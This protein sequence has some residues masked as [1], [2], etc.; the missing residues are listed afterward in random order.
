MKKWLALFLAVVMCCSLLAACGGSD[1]Q[2]TTDPQ[3]SESQ[4]VENPTPDPT[5]SVS[6]EPEP[7]PEPEPEVA[8]DLADYLW[9]IPEDA[10]VE[11]QIKLELRNASLINA[12][13]LIFEPESYS[14][15]SKA[16]TSLRSKKNEERLAKVL[17]AKAGLVQE[18]SVADGIFF[19]WND[20]ESMPIVDGESYTEEQL[21]AASLLGYGYSTVLVK[22]LI[23]DPTQAKGNIVVVSGGAMKGRA[24]GSEGYP[25]VEVFNA[26]GYNC[27]LLQRRLEPYS[28]MDI[29]MDFQR[30]VRTVRYYAEQEG[31]G[32]Q[33]MIAGVGWSGGGATIL[34]A[35]RNCYGDMTPTVY[36]SDYVPD[37]VD[38]VSSDLD[39]A[40]IIYGAYNPDDGEGYVGGDYVGDNPN[41]PAFYINHG[42]ADDTIPVSNAQELYDTLAAKSVSA[43]L[44]LVEGADHGY[45]VG[46]SADL[47]E[48]CSTWVAEA[49]AF[50]QANLGYSTTVRYTVEELCFERD[51]LTIYGQVAMP[52]GEGP[53]PVVILSHGYGGNYTQGL[54]M[55]EAFAAKGVAAYTFDFNGGGNKSQSEGDSRD[56]SVL[57]EAEDLSAV[58]DGLAAMA[59]IDENNIFLCGYS[60]GGFVSTYVAATRPE[61]IKALVAY[62][63][64]YVIH[65][66]AEKNAPDL[67]AL[68]D[69]FKFMGLT[70]SPKYWADV[71]SFSIYDMMPS[72]TRDVL[73]FHGTKD[74]L[75]P[76]EYSQRA[77]GIFPSA[78]LVT[79]EGGAHGNLGA[80]A[81]NRAIEFILEHIGN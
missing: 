66:D 45:G 68:E 60:Q 74:T 79:V 40:L 72:Y 58:I 38:A 46:N 25:A 20:F 44:T 21:D 27:F 1:D 49:D 56:M 77:V 67:D 36:D 6:Q 59:K 14:A 2:P 39:V 50:M 81:D 30:A 48:G 16:V 9:E 5:P 10:T 71:K 23:E 35:I 47:P 65:D 37:A 3:P 26:L 43:Q 51:G 4:T 52:A 33:D 12:M 69:E 11:E 19:I 62:F 41:L 61:D 17:E 31:W 13:E 80:D 57:T 53:F 24:N 54:S 73:I 15:Y 55:A 78:E 42:T 70:V 63:P 29:Y 7:E 18:L 32:G 76:I 8:Q 28:T 75:V 64:A 34:G 22:C